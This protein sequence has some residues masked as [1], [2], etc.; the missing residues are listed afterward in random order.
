MSDRTEKAMDRMVYA[1]ELLETSEFI[2]KSLESSLAKAKE[3]RDIAKEFLDEVTENTT[4]I[5][6]NEWSV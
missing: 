6:R 2:V 5:A 1:I 3:T 4:E